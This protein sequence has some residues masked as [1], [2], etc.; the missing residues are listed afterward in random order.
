MKIFT[1]SMEYLKRVREDDNAIG[2]ELTGVESLGNME[3]RHDIET[4]L[5]NAT[6]PVNF[7]KIFYC[8]TVPNP[9]SKHQDL[10]RYF[11]IKG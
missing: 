8:G 10:K 7:N 5:K 9:T 2:T 3:L 4:I 6:K 1:G 11:M